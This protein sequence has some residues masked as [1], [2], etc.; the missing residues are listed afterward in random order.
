M[1]ISLLNAL[2]RVN[3]AEAVLDV[4]LENARDEYEARLIS[5]IVTLLEGVADSIKEADKKPDIQNI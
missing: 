2:G 1:T 4:W 5:S 3:Q